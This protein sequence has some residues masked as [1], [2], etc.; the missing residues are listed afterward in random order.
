LTI[1]PGSQT[2]EVRLVVSSRRLLTWLTCITLVLL[3][4]DLAGVTSRY[5][6]HHDNLR[7]LVPLF[8]LWEEGNIPTLFSTLLLLFNAVLF[9]AVSHLEQSQRNPSGAW[10]LLAFVFCFLGVDEFAQ[11]H[12]KI[13]AALSFL[14]LSGPLYF[15]WVVPYSLATL[16]VGCLV[17]P[18]L[19]RLDARTRWWLLL[20]GAVY[21]TAA[22][23]FEGLEG[24]RRTA[25]GLD[26]DLGMDLLVAAE[27]TLE[28]A[29]QVILIYPLLS[30]ITAHRARFALT[31]DERSETRY[32]PRRLELTPRLRARG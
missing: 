21:V 27:E 31:V 20:A 32:Q 13:G 19:Y 18:M 1:Q 7:G 9:F 17:I 14:H 30:I 4:A 29:G 3:G 23:G 16:V 11:L 12:E 28:M 5:V 8:D 2:Q 24:M 22:L 25:R 10:R 26:R 15:V 6:F